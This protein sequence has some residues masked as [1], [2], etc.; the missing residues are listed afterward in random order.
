M[1]VRAR[2]RQQ[3]LDSGIRRND[4]PFDK[5]RRWFDKASPELAEGLTMSGFWLLNYRLI[6]L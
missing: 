3:R 6:M 1:T 5:L 4:G 2:G